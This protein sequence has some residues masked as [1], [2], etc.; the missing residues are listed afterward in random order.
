MKRWS[1]RLN[2]ASARRS[3]VDRSPT[4]ARSSTFSAAV[5]PR[6][7]I[8]QRAENIAAPVTPRNTASWMTSTTPMERPQAPIEIAGSAALAIDPKPA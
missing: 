7:R 8:S 6:S 4:R 5:R 3:A 1:R 2:S